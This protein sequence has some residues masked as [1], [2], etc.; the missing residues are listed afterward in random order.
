MGTQTANARYHTHSRRMSIAIGCLVAIGF[1]GLLSMKSSSTP[2]HRRLPA[3][4]QEIAKVEKGIVTLK[5]MIAKKEESIRLDEK[6]NE[7]AAKNGHILFHNIEQEK[8]ILAKRR[9]K[10]ADNERKLEQ[11]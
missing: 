4:P 2:S 7:D 8:A 11:M 5:R 1:L 3:T 6:A 9:A 10:L